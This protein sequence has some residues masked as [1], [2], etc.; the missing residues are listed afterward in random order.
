MVCYF[1][2]EHELHA[3]GLGNYKT[4]GIIATEDGKVIDGY[5]DVCTQPEKT[6]TLVDFLNTY[7]VSATHLRDIVDDFLAQ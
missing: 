1:T 2:T 4:S 7:Q 6:K 3:E 5:L